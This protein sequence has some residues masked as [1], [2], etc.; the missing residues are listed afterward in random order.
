DPVRDELL[1]TLMARFKAEGDAGLRKCIRVLK[2]SPFR[3]ST[4]RHLDAL[5]PDLKSRYW[6]EVY[7]NWHQQDADELHELIDR[8]LEANRPRAALSAV[9]FEFPKIE[10]PSLIRLPKEV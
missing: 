6:K 2:A 10:S 1:N 4:W 3:K 9:Q 7:P 8:L 5:K